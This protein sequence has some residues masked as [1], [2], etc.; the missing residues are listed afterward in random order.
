M[1]A[2]LHITRLALLSVALFLTSCKKTPDNEMPR[3]EGP[4]VVVAVNEPLR[5]FA[6]RIGGEAVMASCPCPIDSDPALWTPDSQA[7]ETFHSADIIL[8]N[9]ADYA[10]WTT[11]TSLPDSKL[12]NTSRGFQT[13][14]LTMK[15]TIRHRHGPEGEHSHEA[16]IGEVWLDPELAIKQ[17]E[18]IERRL[19]A[20]KPNQSVHFEQNL[21]RLKDEL[22]EVRASLLA[23]ITKRP[24]K[25]FAAEP[26][27]EYV[28]RTVDQ[29]VH[30]LAWNNL[31]QPSPTEL[32]DLKKA[33][34]NQTNAVFLL[35]T[36]P[37]Q[38][39]QQVFDD[40]SIEYA[41]F[42]IAATTG[43]KSYLERMSA[44]VRRLEQSLNR[45]R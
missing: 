3:G 6:E 34:S 15:E 36:P 41:V 9:G 28:A 16:T 7:L 25:L 18:R 38:A 2:S 20:L 8:L 19:S 43:E 35:S 5:Y 14:W 31:Q 24:S 37:S 33:V 27:F 13:D 1:P 32:D 4:L 44:N 42:D 45:R 10:R 29:T 21:A 17:A 39:L 22:R 26:A 30:H 40:A 12:V 11:V 23:A